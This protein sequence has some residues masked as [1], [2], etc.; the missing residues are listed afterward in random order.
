[1]SP[2]HLLATA[3]LCVLSLT[4]QAATRF[5]FISPESERDPRTTYDRELLRL[6][7]DGT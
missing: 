1:M 4:G 7:L 5:T 2:L 6:A 3:L